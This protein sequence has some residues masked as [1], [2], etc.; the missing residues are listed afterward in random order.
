VQ[1][2]RQAVVRSHHALAQVE[3]PRQAQPT[4][5][6]HA[7][8]LLVH[9]P[10]GRRAHQ[11]DDPRLVVGQEL[12]WLRRFRQE[13]YDDDLGLRQDSLFELLEPSGEFSPAPPSRPSPDLNHDRRES[14]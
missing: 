13:L 7:K 14:I 6:D 5:H 8:L 11:L 12:A 9:V 1:A 4:A 3:Q 2:L 10:A